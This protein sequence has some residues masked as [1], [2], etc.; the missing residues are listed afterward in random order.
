MADGTGLRLAATH[1]CAMG[2][3]RARLGLILALVLGTSGC[4]TLN[5]ITMGVGIAS[6]MATGKGLASHAIG[7]VT[8]KDCNIL[9]GL[10]RSDRKICEPRGSA[11]AELGFKGLFPR[12]SGPVLRLSDSMAVAAAETPSLE[13]AFPTL[14]PNLRLTDSIGPTIDRTPARLASMEKQPEQHLASL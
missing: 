4:E 12:K 2:L 1:A 5:P 14:V 10:L 8:Q 13:P 11:A 6:Y 3:W 9:G 7:T